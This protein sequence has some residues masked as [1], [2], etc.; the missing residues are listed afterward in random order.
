MLAAVQT[1]TPEKVPGERVEICRSFAYKLN[2]GN[3]ESRDFFC[4]QKSECAADDAME[5][6]AA[7]YHF[8]R[9]QVLASV[10]EYQ[11]EMKGGK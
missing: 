3:Y 2:A 8:C 5:V 9:S 1:I 10:R 4:S 7:L 6:S 11:A